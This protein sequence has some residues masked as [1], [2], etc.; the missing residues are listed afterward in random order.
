[1]KKNIIFICICFAFITALIPGTLMAQ[2]MEDLK[3]RLKDCNDPEC[4]EVLQDESEKIFDAAGKNFGDDF[5]S[6]G[7][8]ITGRHCESV[9][10]ELIY[11]MDKIKTYHNFGNVFYLK[12]LKKL[13]ENRVRFDRKEISNADFTRMSNQIEEQYTHDM[14]E[15]QDFIDYKVQRMKELCSVFHQNMESF[16]TGEPG[17]NGGKP[18]FEKDSISGLRKNKIWQEFE[19]NLSKEGQNIRQAILLASNNAGEELITC[20]DGM[21]YNA[22]APQKGKIFSDDLVDSLEKKKRK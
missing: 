14:H 18:R 2:S 9:V 12:K 1:M 5:A 16:Q 17:K 15:S 6:L 10:D 11:H 21:F 13:K 22:D 19:N 7:N 3:Q 4:R 8:R 20:L